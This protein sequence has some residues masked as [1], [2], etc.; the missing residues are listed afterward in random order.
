MAEAARRT[1]ATDDMIRGIMS[2]VANWENVIVALIA[3]C[4][5]L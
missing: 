5:H 4:L 3:C 2:P 1:S